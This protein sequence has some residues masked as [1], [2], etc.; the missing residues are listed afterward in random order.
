MRL[1]PNAKQITTR[2]FSMW[3]N[4]LGILALLAPELIYIILG[5]DTNPRLWWVVGLALIVCGAAGRLIKQDSVDSPL[6]I[7][8]LAL[9]VAL[10]VPQDAVAMSKAPPASEQHL[11]PDV[12]GTVSE[13]EFLAVATP[14]VGKWEGKRNT[15]YLDTIASPPVWTV[16]F[17][18]T[19]GIKQGDTFTDAKCNTMLGEGLL[20]YRAGLHAYFT[21]ATRAGR[22]TPQRDTAYVSLAYNAGILGIGKSTA[23]RRLNAGDIAGGCAAL[24]WWNKAGGRVIR[25]LVNRRTEEVAMCRIGLPR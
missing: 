25:G 9:I 16:C 24:G 23:T 8:V 18:E 20:T 6:W 15:A 3:A 2:A 19:R 17:G 22:L 21:A 7:V 10:S 14:H 1:V 12:V 5:T 11:V 13:A 4:Y